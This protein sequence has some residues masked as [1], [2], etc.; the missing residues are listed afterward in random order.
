[1]FGGGNWLTNDGETPIKT[2]V[3]P[4]QDTKLTIVLVMIS[5]MIGQDYH[6]LSNISKFLLLLVVDIHN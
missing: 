6:H 1:M 5:Y 3:Y 4:D 2:T